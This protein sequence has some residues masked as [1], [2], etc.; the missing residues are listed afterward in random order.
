MSDPDGVLKGLKVVDFTHVVAGPFCTRL[1]ADHGATV[2]KVESFEGDLMRRLQV[3]F[4]GDLSSAF[5][6][7]NCGKRSIAIDLKRSE[8]RELARSMCRDADIVVENFSA[9]TFGR[10]VGEYDDLKIQNER[11]IMCSISAFGQT[12]VHATLPGFGAV[13][14][15]YSGL[16]QL[17]AD[18][19][20]A[21]SHFGTPLA[22]MNVAI[23][24]FST[25]GI[26]LYSRERTGRGAYIDMSSFDA[27]VSMIDQALATHSVTRGQGVFPPYSRRHQ[28]VV[29]S[30]VVRVS[31]GEWVTFGAPSDVFFARI[32]KSMGRPELIEDARFTT[33][34][35]RVENRDELYDLIE[36]WAAT[37]PDASTMV[38]ELTNSGMPAARVR[39]YRESAEDEHLIQRGTLSPVDLD[40][41]GEVLVQTAPHRLS[42]GSVAPRCGPPHLGEHSIKILGEQGITGRA[43]QALIDSRIVHQW[44]EDAS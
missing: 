38:D 17:A 2:V 22:D 15:A 24:A 14:E 16:M 28:T 1:L 35:A 25:I 3:G 27:L 26:A 23:H 7:Y 8:G 34:D 4:A 12:G 37:F 39:S 10:L 20:G 32:A 33:N 31:S 13:T 21:P 19:S 9:G 40:G 42:A 41:V 44:K 11:L 43:A 30:A 6:Q 18:E 29:P 5:A 36:A